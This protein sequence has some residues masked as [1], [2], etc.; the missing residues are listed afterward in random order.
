VGLYLRPETIA[1][2][3]VMLWQGSYILYGGRIMAFS[4]AKNIF[5]YSL[6]FE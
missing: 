5:N 3:Q 2:D 6:S 1:E 4:H